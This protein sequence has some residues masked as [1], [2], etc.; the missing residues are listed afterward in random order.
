MKA[1]KTRAVIGVILA[2][3]F[4]FFDFFLDAGGT[5]LH[6]GPLILGLLIASL[7]KK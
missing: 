1:Y 3:T 7:G 6:I 2:I 4:M 5:K